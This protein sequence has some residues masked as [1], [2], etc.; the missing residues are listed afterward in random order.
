M[1]RQPSL[2]VLFKSLGCISP[3]SQQASNA[4]Q[5]S[6]DPLPPED[7]SSQDGVNQMA[8]ADLVQLCESTEKVGKRNDVVLFVSVAIDRFDPLLRCPTPKA[9][10][11]SA[12]LAQQIHNEIRSS[13]G[14]W[15][16]MIENDINWLQ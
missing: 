16:S 6:R 10:S 5:R 13:V 14:L 4:L 12:H 2:H 1:P 7:L 11:S 9:S 8:A 15:P 3:A